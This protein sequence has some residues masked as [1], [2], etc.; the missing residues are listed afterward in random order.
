MHAH[1]RAVLVNSRDSVRSKK[2]WL[3]VVGGAR[4]LLLTRIWGL[5]RFFGPAPDLKMRVPVCMCHPKHNQAGPA[6]VRALNT[7]FYVRSNFRTF[8]GAG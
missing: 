1:A 5:E 2:K 7:R 4:L 6:R 3:F 8:T